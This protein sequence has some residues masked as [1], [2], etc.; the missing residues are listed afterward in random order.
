MQNVYKFL[1]SI[2]T[3]WK[4]ITAVFAAFLFF[5][6]AY[7]Y[8]EYEK[9][10][11]KNRIIDFISTFAEKRFEHCLVQSVLDNFLLTTNR[12]SMIRITGIPYESYQIKLGEDV[13]FNI[14]LELNEKYHKLLGDYNPIITSI[15]VDLFK[16]GEAYFVAY[17]EK[18][19]DGNFDVIGYSLRSKNIR[20]KYEFSFLKWSNHI[21]SAD[22][23]TVPTDHA[24]NKLFDSYSFSEIEQNFCGWKEV[25]G[26]S[27]HYMD[28]HGVPFKLSLPCLT[29]G[30]D[31]GDNPVF[32]VFY[33]Y[34]P[35]WSDPDIDRI[36]VFQWQSYLSTEIAW[37]TGHL[38]HLP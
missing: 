17:S 18:D 8:V 34:K 14:V 32:G 31:E 19:G 27:L 28:T 36:S 25:R 37:S 6:S 15:Y 20:E 35:T 29:G 4:T 5:L 22:W 13:D 24:A 33:L 12:K 23:S 1:K 7:Y 3:F 9:T 21:R 38:E 16:I 10:S 2:A 11:C 26:A 30:Q